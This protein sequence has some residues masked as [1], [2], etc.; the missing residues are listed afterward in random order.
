MFWRDLRHKSVSN[1]RTL[2][3]I[4]AGRRWIAL[5]SIFRFLR[6]CSYT[7]HVCGCKNLLRVFLGCKSRREGHFSFFSTTTLQASLIDSF[8][9]VYRFWIWICRFSHPTH[10][11]IGLIFQSAIEKHTPELVN[12]CSVLGDSNK[13]QCD[14]N[15]E[16]NFRGSQDA[17]VSNFIH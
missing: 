13:I 12:A 3:T 10:A 8:I 2:N 14:L 5:I 17:T 1:L 15:T 7:I 4:L 16:I 9:W 6:V 11:E